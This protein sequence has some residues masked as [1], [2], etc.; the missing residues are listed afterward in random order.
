MAWLRKLSQS[1]SDTQF[2][3]NEFLEN[4][5]EYQPRF[6]VYQSPDFPHVFLGG[7]NDLEEAEAL[8]GQPICKIVDCRDMPEIE[9]SSWDYATFTTVQTQFDSKVNDLVQKIT[10]T[11]CPIFVHC[12][13]GANRSVSVLA[14]ALAQLTGKPLNTILSDMKQVRSFVSPQD[15]YYLMALQQSPS[16][17]PEFKQQRFDELDQDFPLIQPGLPTN[18]PFRRAS[19]NWLQKLASGYRSHNR[20]HSRN[21]T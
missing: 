9:E 4:N 7:E 15:P 10:T 5:P 19:M 20:S 6:D 8:A 21:C 17:T 14:A 12:A 11:D 2:W 1:F 16:E 13:M 3:G 18:T